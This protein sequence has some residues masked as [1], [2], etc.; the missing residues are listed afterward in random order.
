[1]IDDSSFDNTAG[2]YSGSANLP[3]TLLIPS[4]GIELGAISFGDAEGNGNSASGVQ[5]ILSNLVFNNNQTWTIHARWWPACG[6][7][8]ACV[9]RCLFS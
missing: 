9:G 4:S 5:T 6:G 7:P 2:S 3:A 8:S 1:M